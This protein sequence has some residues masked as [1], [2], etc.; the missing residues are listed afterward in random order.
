MALEEEHMFQY[1]LM[2]AVAVLSAAGLS[3]LQ[4]QERF[5]PFQVQLDFFAGMMSGDEA[6]FQRAMTATEKELAANPDNGSALVWHGLGVA[7]LSQRQAQAGNLQGAM[8][9]LQKGL[10][11][12]A[13]AV[14][15][16]PDNI[17]VRI[18]RG[19]A[20]REISREMPPGMSEPLLEAARTDFQHAFDLQK[21]RLDQVATPHPLGELL[22]GLGDIYS[23]QGKPDEA[24][25]Y[26]MMIQERLPGTEYAARGAEWTATRQPLAPARTQCIGCHIRK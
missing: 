11:E 5:D 9:M 13:R 25:K 17:G 21:A 20:L 24:A 10:A 6:R 26:Y 19:S 12:M 16:E 2:L 8:A 14:E 15:L 1:L 23:R 4:A 22:Q 18:P 7:M 3:T